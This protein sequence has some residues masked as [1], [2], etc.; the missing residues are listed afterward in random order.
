M[1]CYFCEIV[2]QNRM[3]TNCSIMNFP[4]VQHRGIQIADNYLPSFSD[5]NCR[6]SHFVLVLKLMQSWF[7]FCC[8]KNQLNKLQFEFRG[9]SWC[10]IE[11]N[12]FWRKSK[13]KIESKHFQKKLSRTKF[14]IYNKFSYKTI[15]NS[16]QTFLWKDLK[17]LI[18]LMSMK[19]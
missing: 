6:C 13:F 2:C 15:T 8:M 7:M 4:A 14:L 1:L 10:S 9:V 12:I 3:D 19:L 16:K 11:K 17:F 5:D 18:N